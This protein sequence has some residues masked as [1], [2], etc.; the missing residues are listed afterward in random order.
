MGAA[1]DPLSEQIET[2]MMTLFR[3]QDLN[4]NGVLEEAELIKLNEKIAMLHY[5]KDTD[6]QIVRDKYHDI[7]HTQLSPD[8]EPVKYPAF[9]K[10]MLQT[11]YELDPDKPS[12]EMILDGFVIEAKE[13]REA[14]RLASLASE[15]DAPWMPSI[16]DDA[17][18]AP[19]ASDGPC[20]PSTGCSISC[21]SEWH[22]VKSQTTTCASEWA[23][24]VQQVAG[25][26][27]PLV[28]RVM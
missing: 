2:L 7:F 21:V 24:F 11:L 15:S 26:K 25:K 8:G 6:R 5:G 9:R 3:L 28:G 14:F 17:A 18:L 22:Q 12:Q 10:Y 4:G 23:G 13:G 1:E 20:G 19:V 27:E 16:Q